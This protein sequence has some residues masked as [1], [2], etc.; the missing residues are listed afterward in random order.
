MPSKVENCKLLTDTCGE[1]RVSDRVIGKP[2]PDSNV[3]GHDHEGRPI[4]RVDSAF[5]SGTPATDVQ[6]RLRSIDPRKSDSVIWNAI[7]ALRT[8]PDNELEIL[9]ATIQEYHDQV[10]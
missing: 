4:Y 3:V 5:S 2:I 1:R 10:K 8:N 7:D 6:E 9:L